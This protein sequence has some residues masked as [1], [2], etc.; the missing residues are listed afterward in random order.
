[1]RYW[2]IYCQVV[3]EENGWTSSVGTPTFYLDAAIL[4]FMPE[5]TRAALQMR[6]E[7]V[8]RSIVDPLSK[9]K[10]VH[11]NCAPVGDKLP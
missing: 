10:A 3:T 11:V 2:A 1:M 4:G 9:A 6:V 8:A 7:K 5:E